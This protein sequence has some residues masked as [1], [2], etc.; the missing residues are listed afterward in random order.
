[1][2]EAE[3][4]SAVSTK[5][6]EIVVAA[7]FLALGLLVMWDSARLGAKWGSDGPE[8]GYFRFYIGLIISVSAVV[9]A[10]RAFLGKDVK[11]ASF[12]SVAALKMVLTVFIPTVIYVLLIDGI[13][14]I[15]GL[16][17]YVPSILFIAAFMMI[18]GKY[19]WLKTAIVS[20]CVV[21]VFFLMFEVWFKVPLPKG[22]LEAALGFA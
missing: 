19:K 8:A 7:A 9:N 5:T 3:E 1:M 21:I 2:N 20:I 12:V 14:P 13:G 11:G 15:P 16:G 17:I 6:M 22:P 10:I 18:L 4:K